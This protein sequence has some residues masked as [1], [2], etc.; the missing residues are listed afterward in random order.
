MLIKMTKIKTI[1]IKNGIETDNNKC[2]QGHRATRYL[3]DLQCKW[4]MV[5]YLGKT[6][7]QFLRNLNIHL[8]YHPEIL[9]LGIYPRD[10][11]T[12]VHTQTCT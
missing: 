3:I 1:M 4:Q 9:F 6:V 8:F 5:Q 11:K 7:R 12:H 10:M 2:W